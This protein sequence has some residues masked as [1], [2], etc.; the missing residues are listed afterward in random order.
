[1]NTYNNLKQLPN[2]W[3]DEFKKSEIS[4]DLLSPVNKLNDLHDKQNKIYPEVDNIYNA[5]KLCSYKDVKVVIL[6]QDPYHQ[7]GV[8]NGLA[9]SVDVGSKIPASLRN[10]YKEID[11]DIGSIMN[12]NGD[13]NGW[14]K[15]GVLLLNCSLS[16][17][18]SRP[19]SHS[20]IGWENVLESVI[21]LL[22]RKKNIVY[23]LWGS[24]SISKRYLI[25]EN[26]HIVFSAPHPSPLSAYRGFFGCKHFSKTNTYLAKNNIKPINW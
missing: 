17:E 7:K 6:G 2:K 15:Q 1:M 26:N 21:K 23:L 25:N 4:L 11:S 20:S 5:F 13:L 14:A 8:A 24:N 9:F 16:V 19:G 10:I 3:H 18:D 12:K 22:N